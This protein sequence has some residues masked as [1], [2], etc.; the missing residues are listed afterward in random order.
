MTGTI[1]I[2]MNENRRQR[3]EYRRSPTPAGVSSNCISKARR[4]G[5]P[6][7]PPPPSPAVGKRRPARRGITG[8]PRANTRAEGDRVRPPVGGSNGGYGRAKARRARPGRG[9]RPRPAA[10]SEAATRGN[11]SNCANR[12][13][14][15]GPG[16]FRWRGFPSFP[17]LPDRGGAERDAPVPSGMFTT[18]SRTAAEEG[19]R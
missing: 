11:P 5:R 18:P 6:P 16:V 7:P 1:G 4:D 13:R 3:L 2:P 19:P 8:L 14:P 9:K 12:A 10:P 17:R 15:P